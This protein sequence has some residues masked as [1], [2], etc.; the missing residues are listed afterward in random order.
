M[1]DRLAVMGRFQAGDV[2]WSRVINHLE[3]NQLGH[4]V[5]QLRAV[6][7]TLERE[8]D[9]A[10]QQVGRLRAA[11]SWARGMCTDEVPHMEIDAGLG[12]A[13]DDTARGQSAL[14]TEDN[15]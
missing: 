11:I 14:V 8:R 7:G 9:E 3:R 6:V 2:A 15:Q 5:T 13:L 12:R 10:R 4:D 1:T